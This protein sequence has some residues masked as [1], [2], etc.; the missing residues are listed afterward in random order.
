MRRGNLIA[1]IESGACSAVIGLTL[2]AFAPSSVNAEEPLGRGAL[3]LIR[4]N[5]TLPKGKSCCVTGMA[6][7]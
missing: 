7:M 3:S 4:G 1:L 2:I 6:L 5:M